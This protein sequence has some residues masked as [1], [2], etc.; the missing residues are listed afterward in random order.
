MHIAHL[1]F[2][3]YKSIELLKYNVGW[4]LNIHEHGSEQISF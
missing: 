3:K 2:K 4:K 1:V